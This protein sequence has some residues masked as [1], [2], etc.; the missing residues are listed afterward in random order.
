MGDNDRPASLS[1]MFIRTA[2]LASTGAVGRKL[3][4]GLPFLTYVSPIICQDYI[5]SRAQNGKRMFN[6][7]TVFSVNQV[8]IPRLDMLIMSL[9]VIGGLSG[10][11]RFR[12]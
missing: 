12:S 7:I 2:K 10:E 4:I 11:P 1:A 6:P 3:R 5:S 9:E 8:K